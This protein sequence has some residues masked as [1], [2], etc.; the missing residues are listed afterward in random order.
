MQEA[1]QLLQFEHVLEEILNLVRNPYSNI[2]GA[3]LLLSAVVVFVLLFAVIVIAVVTRPDPRGERFRTQEL[4]HYLTILAAH[5][6][7]SD[8]T[9]E[10]FEPPSPRERLRGYAM[11]P[12]LLVTCAVVIVFGVAIGASSGQSSVCVACHEITPHSEVVASGG[13]DPHVAVN[14]VRCHESSGRLGIVTIEAPERLGHMMNGL[15]VDPR[16]TSYGGVASSACYRCHA[17]I[18]AQITEDVDR[19]IRMSHKQPLEAGAEC[20]DCHTLETGV[21][22]RLTSGMAPCLRC[23]DGENQSTTCSVCHTKDVSAATRS[24]AN[25]AEMTGR[26]LV[27]TPDCGSCHDEATQCDPCHGG[28]RMPHSQVFLW[29]GHA[30]EGV[31][32]V[33]F[34]DGRRCGRCHTAERR[35]CTRCHAFFPGHPTSEFIQGHTRAS[36]GACGPCHDN[37]AYVAGRDFCGLCHGEPLIAK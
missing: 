34:S 13:T 27:P 33:W 5:R 16:P 25:L 8:V 24:R 6:D 2:T 10:G 14:C 15:R 20:R 18:V 23:H 26:V 28:V 36:A 7:A 9:L 29:W 12:S 3:L 19:G 1:L 30:R 11:L 4:K 21:I 22:S 32:D 17:R 37:K 35:P 31:K